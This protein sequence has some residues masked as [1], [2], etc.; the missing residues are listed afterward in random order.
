MEN[1]IITMGGS[2]SEDPLL[3][4][5][6]AKTCII[7][8]SKNSFWCPMGSMLT[9]R[10]TE[11]QGACTHRQIVCLTVVFSIRRCSDWRICVALLSFDET[12]RSG[13]CGVRALCLSL[14]GFKVLWC[15]KKYIYASLNAKVGML[16]Y[17]I[18]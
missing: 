7:I 8:H 18:F 12:L 10:L 14:H 15:N 3:G 6:R 17:S 1:I 13:N 5:I 9:H 4:S 11:M 16:I 2:C